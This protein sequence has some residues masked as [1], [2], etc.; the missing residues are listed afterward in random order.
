[1]LLSLF[2]LSAQVMD[3]QTE[4]FR[5]EHADKLS[6]QYEYRSVYEYCSFGVRRILDRRFAA[7]AFKKLRV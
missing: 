7:R 6:L 3:E 2:R 5:S 1:M 4:V